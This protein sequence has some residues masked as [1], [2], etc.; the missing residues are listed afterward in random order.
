LSISGQ[1]GIV[2]VMVLHSQNLYSAAQTRELDRLAIQQEGIPGFTLM[3]R[4][5][6][7]T[8]LQIQSRWPDANRLTVVCGIGN[9]G[10]D[11]CLIA[12]LAK[13]QGWQVQVFQLGDVEKQTG[14]AKKAR[15]SMN[16]VGLRAQDFDP[17]Q[18][19]ETDIIVDALLGTGL[20]RSVEGVWLS[21]IQA[22]NRSTALKVAVDIPSG[23]NADTGCELGE[24]VKAD[25][26]VTF[27][28]RKQ[29]L[30]TADG[31]ACS[32]KIHFEDLSIPE[33]LYADVPSHH[34]LLPQQLQGPLLN[35]RQQN[36]HKGSHG[37]VLVV[38]GASGMNGAVMLAASAAL[39]TGCGLVSVATHGK[40][41]SVI[42]LQQPEIMSHGIEDMKQLNPL[43]DAA[44]VIV[45]GPG[46]GQLDWS[47][48]IFYHII[49]THKPL[50]LDA[51]AL[52]ILVNNPQKKAN[53]VLT[54]HPGEAARLLGCSTNEIQSNRYMAVKKIQEK[55]D[56]ICVLKG[57]GSLIS[58][59][60][61]ISACPLGNPGMASAGMG[62][63]LSGVL[64]SCIA[65]AIH[66]KIDIIEAVLFAVS[67]HAA[68]GDACALV[69]G[70]K[71]LL[72]SDLFPYI[73][74]LINEI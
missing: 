29:G 12:L 31:R 6:E 40:H 18:L 3:Q 39:R 56:G 70:E 2:W 68:A 32:G 64:G 42:N 67:L 38:G 55:Y 60:D 69:D 10:G 14:D 23:L 5:A 48:D 25:L 35:P 44:D 62:D 8:F 19:A 65:Q 4:A 74:K 33:K 63:V 30:Y 13:Q 45:L 47:T 28:G 58:C 53:W 41:A 37:H 46:L 43:M 11:G 1:L 15:E 49:N 22:I 61:K 7:C 73:K 34:G 52:N 20:H 17:N 36:S 27:I 24:A 9:N 72:A 26:T 51:D 71:G 50:V 21:T 16:A 54:P 66:N 57:A 59:D